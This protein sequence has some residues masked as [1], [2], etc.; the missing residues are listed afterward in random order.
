MLVQGK[1]VQ[2]LEKIVAERCGLP[3]AIAMN[4]CTSTL[5]M[6]LVSLGVGP[7]DLVIVPSYSWIATANVV[8][9]CGAHP[10]FVDIDGRTFTIDPNELEK[11][12][13]KLKRRSATSRRLK[14]II[15]V[16][17]FGQMADVVAIRALA[18]R[19]GVPVIEDAACALGASYDGY[20]AGSAGIMGC[21]SMHPRKAV[22]TGEGG[23]IVTRNTRMAR[24]LQALRSHGQMVTASGTEFMVPG[25]N[26]RMTDFQG[27]LGVSQMAKLD[28]ILS[29]RREMAAIYDSLFSNTPVT[30]P[31]VDTRGISVY[32]SYVV[33]VPACGRRG[34]VKV[35]ELL[36]ER[37]IETNI[38]TCHMPLTRYFR[39][40]Y[41]YKR[42]D[43]PVTDQ[44]FSSAMSLPF[45]SGLSSG[46]QKKVANELIRAIGDST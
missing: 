28:Q 22:T 39:S 24:M 41:C 4:S 21:F 40:R 10:S 2:L 9:L 5:H 1:N 43:F 14:A 13:K 35:I 20:T 30:A 44:V 23:I 15:V 12:I 17:T 46:D 3:H 37:G 25:Y 32:Q 33:K 42:G 36:K 45:H 26:L 6:C 38:G 27:A 11:H 19:Y 34:P 29:K 31:F 16:H 8:S 18:D 7:G